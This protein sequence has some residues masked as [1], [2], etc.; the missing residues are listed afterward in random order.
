MPLCS[1]TSPVRIAKIVAD[2]DAAGYAVGAHAELK[3]APRGVDREHPRIELLRRKGLTA[4]RA[5]P[6]AK[7]MH[8][9]T[10]ADRIAAVWEELAPMC[11]WLDDHVGPSTLPPSDG[12]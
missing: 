3:T 8:T 5:W 10:A 1:T 6:P 11:S 2:G 9:R 7:W 4:S 12:F